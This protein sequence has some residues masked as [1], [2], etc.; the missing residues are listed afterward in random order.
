MKAPTARS[1]S[2]GHVWLRMIL[3][4]TTLMLS[5]CAED[6]PAVGP[7]GGVD[8]LA[9]DIPVDAI[10]DGFTRA[11]CASTQDCPAVVAPCEYAACVAGVGCVVLALPDGAVCNHKESCF[12]G[13]T[14][15]AALCSGQ[16]DKDCD[17][18]NPCT[19]D[20]CD[21]GACSHAP[22]PDTATVACDDNNV[23]THGDQCEG[24]T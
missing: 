19:V 3:V 18:D 2:S 20:A 10:V 24:D 13:G 23:C 8:V 6:E 15:K 16:T 7:A 5:A 21:K 4:V 11:P 17:D 22:T 14:C 9:A 1:M 12:K